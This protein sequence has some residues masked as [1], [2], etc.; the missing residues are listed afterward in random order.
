[1]GAACV[2][3]SPCKT[4][5][6]QIYFACFVDL[7]GF[8]SFSVIF[9]YTRPG[10]QCIAPWSSNQERNF[11]ILKNLF[12]V[13][14]LNNFF[15]LTKP[16]LIFTPLHFPSTD[17]FFEREP[18]LKMM[19]PKMIRMNESNQL[20]WDVDKDMLQVSGSVDRC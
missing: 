9:S 13:I 12:S 14:F 2:R 20:E 4:S 11:R 18:D 19:F 15:F 5:I 1:M 8:F 3:S 7:C 16:L 10:S 17:S 6:T